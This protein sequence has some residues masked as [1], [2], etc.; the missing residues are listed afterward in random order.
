MAAQGESSHWSFRAPQS[1][2]SEPKPE[3]TDATSVE[4]QFQS[5]DEE[6][7][8]TSQTQTQTSVFTPSY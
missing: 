2:D 8:P 1:S 3:Q 4:E 7:P 5:A 6:S